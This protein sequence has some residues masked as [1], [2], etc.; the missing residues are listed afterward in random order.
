ML[1]CV[2]VLNRVRGP[3]R[4]VA[5]AVALLAA[6]IPASAHAILKESVPAAHAVLSG[7]NVAI[8]LKF[9]SRIDAAH[10]RLTLAGISGNQNLEIDKKADPDLLVGQAKDVKA[11][12]YRI[13]WQV[14][15]VDGHITRGEVPFTVH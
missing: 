12:E 11:G 9:N 5:F 1:S 4:T 10:S 14:L 7:G 2:P 15:A 3:F 6:A 13:Q 8:R